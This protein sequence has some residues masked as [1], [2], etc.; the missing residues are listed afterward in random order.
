MPRVLVAVVLSF[1]VL[2]APASAEVPKGPRGAAFYTPPKHLAGPH[3][4]LIWARRQ[5]GSDAL[6]GARANELLL[7]R[8]R[9]LRGKTTAVSASLAL[10]KGKPPRG[11]W[12]VITYAHGT[13]GAADA[14]APT[15]GYDAGGLVSYAFPLLERWLKAGYA[16]VRTDYDGLG[17]PG[18]H[19]YLVGRSEA[20][21]VL[22][23]VRAARGF[24]PRLSKRFVIAGHSQGGHA[25]LFA[26]ADAPKWVPELHL[27]GTVALAPASHLRTQFQTAVSVRAAA[28]GLGG[29]IALGLRAVETVDPS[30]GLR[31]LL[32]PA[33]AALY[34]QTRTACLDRLRASDSFGGL[35]LDQ[36]FRAGVD[37]EP[38][39]RVL[40]KN[41]P[42]H[43]RMRTPVRIEQGTAD[44]TVFPA[45]TDALVDEYKAH[46][47][48]VI[49]RTY[50]GVSHGGVVVAAADD[51]TR[52]IT[53]RAPLRHGH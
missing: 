6:K 40:G 20:R 21:S 3:G 46:G 18:I 47:V 1:L 41:D 29:I 49:Y 5:T 37:L 38:V 32:T 15:R 14:C 31:S 4:G 50:A 19:Q 2:A 13:T 51:A 53:S 10:P 48:K 26:A 17:T 39:L 7:Y 12:P 22:D 11:G 35:P 27:R 52:W 43:L 25:A 45:F 33:A 24:D 34:P 30:L 23:A 42:E 16:V 8:S 44:G 36:L 28:G 9:S